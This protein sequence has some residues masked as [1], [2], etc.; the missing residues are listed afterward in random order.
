MKTLTFTGEQLATLIVLAAESDP[1]DWTDDD[2]KALIYTCRS[3]V[4]KREHGA[5]ATH[6]LSARVVINY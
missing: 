6:M 4:D 1:E 5:E 3:A 2:I